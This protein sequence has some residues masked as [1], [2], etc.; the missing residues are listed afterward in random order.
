MYVVVDMYRVGV[1]VLCAPPW[2]FFISCLNVLIYLTFTASFGSIS[3]SYQHSHARALSVKFI[4]PS[5]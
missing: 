2:S 3:A 4:F 1:S 5:S